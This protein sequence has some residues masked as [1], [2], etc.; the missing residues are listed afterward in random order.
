[1]ADAPPAPASS[2]GPLVAALVLGVVALVVVA[3]AVLRGGAMIGPRTDARAL[4]QALEDPAQQT[5]AYQK[6]HDLGPA[7]VP[8]L[9]AAL[10]DPT[11]RARGEVVELLGR[12]GDDRARGPVLALRDPDLATARVIALGRLKGPD[13]LAEVL[14]ALR[15]DDPGVQIPALQALVDWPEATAAALADEVSRFLAS[16]LTGLR[17]AAVRFLGARRHGPAVPALIGRL[18]DDDASVR[19]AAAWALDQ[20]G[21]PAG[22]AAVDSAL[23]T[24]AVTLEED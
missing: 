15:S 7:A 17:E 14:A 3:V 4:V 13:A 19:Q 11:F 16:E 22:L 18:R 24:G 2:R 1:M 8:D 23:K 5:S 9:L 21:D 6:L 12:S 20:I 10:G